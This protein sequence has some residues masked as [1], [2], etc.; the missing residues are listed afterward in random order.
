MHRKKQIVCQHCGQEQVVHLLSG[1]NKAAGTI[2]SQ[3]VPCV[4]CG[5]TFPVTNTEKILDGPYEV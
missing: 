5:K 2:D 1:D 3:T 4:K